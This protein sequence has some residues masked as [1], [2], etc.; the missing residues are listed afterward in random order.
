MRKIR[1]F[2][3]VFVLTLAFTACNTSESLNEIVDD[4]EI[5]SV[6]STDDDDDN[7]DETPPSTS[8]GGN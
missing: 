5:E 8:T 3:I 2:G 1:L 7:D 4:V 6:Q